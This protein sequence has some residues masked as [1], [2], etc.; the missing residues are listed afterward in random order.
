MVYMGLT[1]SLVTFEKSAG[2]AHVE[3]SGGGGVPNTRAANE[4]LVPWHHSPEYNLQFAFVSMIKTTILRP[5]LHG[6][7]V[8]ITM[9]DKQIEVQQLN[10]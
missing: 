4:N 5:K 8:P 7:L 2:S 10:D 9:Y 3:V 1:N 6:K